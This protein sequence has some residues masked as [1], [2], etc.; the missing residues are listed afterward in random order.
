MALLITIAGLALTA[1]SETPTPNPVLLPLELLPTKTAIPIDSNDNLIKAPPGQRVDMVFLPKFL[2]I[3]IFDQA[4]EGALKAH[5]ELGNPG[6]LDLIGPLPNERN[7]IQI[8]IARNAIEQGTQA[9]M[10]SNNAGDKMVA[11]TQPAIENGLTI[12]TWDSSIPTTEGQQL[13]VAQ[14]DFAETGEVMA[15]MATHILGEEGG[16]FAILSASQDSSNQNAWIAAMQTVLQKPEYKNLKLLEVVYGEDNANI[17]YAKTLEL[18]ARYPDLELIVAPTTIGIAA[19]ARALQ[20][21]GLCEQ[22]QVSGLGLP[23]EMVTYTLD[24]CAPEFALWSFTD[25]GYLTYYTT[26]LLATGT[27]KGEAGESFKAGQLGIYTIEEDPTREDGLRVLMGPFTIY[28]AD[29]V[30]MA[31]LQ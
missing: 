18:I 17:S 15:N 28:T 27:I 19:A 7:D 10:I 1:C 21:N 25:L 14:V 26:Y 23:E 9:L 20:D 2:G 4:Y 8:K 30:V 6:K 11:V 29:N 24:G 3:M 31:L 22:V 5:T 13:F 16:K 12:V